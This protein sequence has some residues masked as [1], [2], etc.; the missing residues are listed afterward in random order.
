MIYLIGGPPKCGKTTLAKK[1]AK[2]LQTPWISTDALQVVAM[3]Y[4]NKSENRKQF[5][6]TVIRKKTK[7]INDAIYNNYSATAIIKLYR[8][9]AQSTQK[10]ID[11]VCA[12]KIADG[13]DYIIEGLHIE[14]NSAAH[15]IKKYG[16]KNI[17]AIFLLKKDQQK[18]VKSIEKSSTPNDWIIAKTKD[19]SIY[20]K[21]AKMVCEYGSIIE[22][23]AKKAGLKSLITDDRFEKQLLQAG[24]YMAK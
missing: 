20:P 7:K 23:E 17:K 11:A 4:L 15:L 14:P 16:S 6:W 1:L 22:K 9:A 18:F 10:A 5:P 21:I 12:S 8:K 13:I 3:A 24:H 2:D 19:K